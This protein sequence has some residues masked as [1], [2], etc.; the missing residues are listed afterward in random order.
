MINADAAKQKALSTATMEL[1][2]N[3]VKES[4]IWGKCI[5]QTTRLMMHM[6]AAAES[7]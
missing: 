3:R 6:I 7:M 5:D 2:K 4:A 1:N